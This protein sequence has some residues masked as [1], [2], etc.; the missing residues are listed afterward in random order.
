MLEFLPTTDSAIAVRIDGR[1][2]ARDF[3]AVLDRVEASL[4]AR[5]RTHFYVE[6]EALSGV[7][8][9]GMGAYVVRATGLLGRLERFGRIALVADQSWIRWAARIESALLP[10]VRYETLTLA[11][12]EQALAW[13]EGK[14]EHPHRPALKIIDTDKPDVLGF[15]IDGRVTVQELEALV[16][17]FQPA[18]DRGEPL[19]VVGRVRDFGGVEMS[20]YANRDYFEMKSR[21]L[22]HVERYAV[23]GG[24]DWLKSWIA[25][26]DPLFRVDMRHFQADEEAQAW[27][28]VGASPTGERPAVA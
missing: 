17:A 9:D 5:E 22:R 6:V 19:R 18:L 15:E 25:M 21:M 23:V 10:K 8:L 14:A 13:V 28:W 2:E 24:P 16:R 11:E 7:D 4:S 3:G 20:A 26:L 12:R 1:V 27:A